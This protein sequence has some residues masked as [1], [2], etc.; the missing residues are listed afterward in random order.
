MALHINSRPFLFLSP[1][2][3]P[4]FVVSL[5]CLPLLFITPSAR[6]LSRTLRDNLKIF[7][8]YKWGGRVARHKTTRKKRVKREKFNEKN[9][10]ATFSGSVVPRSYFFILFIRLSRARLESSR[11]KVPAQRQG[12]RWL[13]LICD[14]EP[15]PRQRFTPYSLITWA[16]TSR[17]SFFTTRCHRYCFTLKAFLDIWWRA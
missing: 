16:T 5:F 1:G 2:F 13:E 11:A 14:L 15:L 9:V 4:F 12:E 6:W 10:S 8:R 3:S 7:F 17:K